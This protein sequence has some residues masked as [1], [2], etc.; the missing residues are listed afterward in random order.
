M[1]NFFR[2]KKMSFLAVKLSSL[3]S[4]LKVSKEILQSASREVDKMFN[5]KYFP[6]IP[7]ADPEK[8][9]VSDLERAEQNPDSEPTQKIDPDPTPDPGDK[10]EKEE[11][12]DTQPPPK[13]PDLEKK[14]VD[15][16]VKSLFRKIS[17][18]IHPDKLE[19]LEEGYEKQRKL[20]LYNEARSALDDNDILMMTK[21]A[22][23]LKIDTPEV[24]ENTL[25]NAEKQIADIKKELN[26][27]E[28]TVVWHWFF[29][30]DP[31]KKQHILEELFKRMYAGRQ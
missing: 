12:E 31:E 10:G 22:M 3:R 30:D 6:E 8:E 21:V 26:H 7:V 1:K 28:S 19:H 11:K 25:K 15:P 29:T 9:S 2:K 23:E 17:F 13:Q 16:E 18:K 14:E 20:E 24:T 5:E 4:E 27:I